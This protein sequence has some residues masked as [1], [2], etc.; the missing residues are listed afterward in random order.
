MPTRN[1][2]L[3][4]LLTVVA[5]LAS[6]AMLTTAQ[7]QGTPTTHTFPEAPGKTVQGRFW[8]YWETHGGLSQQGFPISNELGE[9]S[10]VDGKLYTVQYFERSVFELHPENPIPS[11]V[12]LS[13]LGGFR[14]KAKYPAHLGRGPA[15]ITHSLLAIQARRWAGCSGSI[16]RVMAGWLSRASPFRMNL[17]KLATWMARATPSSISSGRCSSYI[18]RTPP[19]PGCSYPS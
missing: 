3:V 2:R 14:Y 4:L 9:V 8:Q 13:L 1:H 5:L 17:R 19:P 6:R 11:D 12:L 16:G 10:D 18:L 15:P 7:A